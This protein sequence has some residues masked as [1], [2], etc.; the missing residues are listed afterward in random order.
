MRKIAVIV[1]WV[2]LCLA[3][4][5]LPAQNYVGV[6]AGYGG[7][8]S[9]LYDIPNPDY[10]YVWGLTNYGVSWKYYSADRVVGAVQVDLE[11]LQRGFA[12]ANY[13]G[14]SSATYK[15]TL[16]AI[17]IPFSWQPHVYFFHRHLRVFLNAGVNLS[18]NVASSESLTNKTG[19]MFD[20]PYTMQLNRDNRFGYGLSGGFGFGLLFGRMEYFLEGRY[21]FGYSDILKN[22]VIYYGNPQR[23]PLDNINLSF[24]IFYRLGKGG[25]KSPT[26]AQINAGKAKA[27]ITHFQKMDQ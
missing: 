18:Y 4:E 5:K 21:Y 27:G 10:R 20:R 15:R 3:C 22:G 13:Q 7:G 23:S 8:T 6:R 25:I 14:D 2:L 11:F 26:Q 1:V 16:S 12:I 9:R 17:N 19:V 24:G